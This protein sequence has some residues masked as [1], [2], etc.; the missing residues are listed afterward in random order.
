[1]YH[2]VLTCY[3]ECIINDLIIILRSVELEEKK[4]ELKIEIDK[5]IKL[6][7]EEEYLFPIRK[8]EISLLVETKH[9]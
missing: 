9:I 8:G 6:M 5:Y 2:N 7:S 1:M 3:V 4:I